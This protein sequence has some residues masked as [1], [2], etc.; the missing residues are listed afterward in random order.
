MERERT[1][2]QMSPGNKREERDGSRNTTGVG[3]GHGGGGPDDLEERE[4]VGQRMGIYIYTSKYYPGLGNVPFSSP[5]LEI[6][7]KPFTA[8][9][10]A[11]RR[12]FPDNSSHTYI[13]TYNERSSRTYSIDIFLNRYFNKV[14]AN[15]GGESPRQGT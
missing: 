14:L 7:Q 10:K 13:H 5:L 6:Q 4:K 12:F 2:W 1:G 11:S 15:D 8:K 9:N 3:I